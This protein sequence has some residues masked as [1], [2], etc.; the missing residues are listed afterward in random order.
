MVGSSAPQICTWE[1]GD[2]EFPPDLVAQIA[3]V[4]FNKLIGLPAFNDSDELARALT[5]LE[6]EEKP[7][8]KTM[9]SLTSG[10]SGVT[11][12]RDRLRP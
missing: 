1:R 11:S 6:Y 7:D 4:L 5:T 2:K 8:Q 10:N 9:D 12:L 3:R